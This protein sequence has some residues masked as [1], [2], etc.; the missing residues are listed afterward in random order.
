MKIH[1][2]VMKHLTLT[3]RRVVEYFAEHGGSA[4]EIA[5]AL[6]ISER[7]VYKALYKYRRVASKLGLDAS[8]FSFRR[9]VASVP[10]PSLA[11]QGRS[12]TADKYQGYVSESNKPSVNNIE[13]KEI[14]SL[15]RR[16]LVELERVNNNLEK[17]AS[18]NRGLRKPLGES[19][20]E[21]PSTGGEEGLPS[22]AS[23]NPWLRVLSGRSG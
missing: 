18:S 10:S 8:N 19:V 17:I 22:F 20:V 7:T 13:C 2:D 3:E 14:V 21:T 9:R 12:V 4:K 11:T 16:I 5:E 15:L 1:S 23:N 6:N